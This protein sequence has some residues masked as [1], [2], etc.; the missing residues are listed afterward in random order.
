MDNQRF[1]NPIPQSRRLEESR[2]QRFKTAGK[3][4][5]V[6]ERFSAF[7]WEKSQDCSNWDLNLLAAS[8]H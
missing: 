7:T 3:I 1:P 2:L 4:A 5:E 8:L 6:L